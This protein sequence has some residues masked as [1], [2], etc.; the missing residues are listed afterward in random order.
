MGDT[1]DKAKVISTVKGAL[2]NLV[3][4]AETGMYGEIDILLRMLA[5]KQSALEEYLP[6]L[7]NQV[8]FFMEEIKNYAE[9]PG[10]PAEKLEEIKKMKDQ[11]I[12]FDKPK[13]SITEKEI[14]QYKKECYGLLGIMFEKADKGEWKEADKLNPEIDTRTDAIKTQNKDEAFLFDLAKNKIIQMFREKMSAI[15]KEKSRQEAIAIIEQIK[16]MLEEQ[17]II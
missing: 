16:E 9:D 4:C 7:A 1:L 5:D 10:H 13:K 11:I 14:I 12:I 3:L 8:K 15:E 6:I 2:E 17:R